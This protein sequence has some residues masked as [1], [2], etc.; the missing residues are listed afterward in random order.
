[1][2]DMTV[3][4]EESVEKPNGHA[5]LVFAKSPGEAQVQ[6]VRLNAATTTPENVARSFVAGKKYRV[7]IEEVADDAP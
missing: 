4:C 2:I 3:T 7:R 5:F 6:Y 1:M